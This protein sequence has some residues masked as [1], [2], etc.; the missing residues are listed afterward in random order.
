MKRESFSDKIKSKW[1]G[2]KPGWRSC[3]MIGI[4]A[5]ILYLSITY[6]PYAAKLL[7]ALL[8]ASAPILIGC[9]IAYPLNI[10]MS[11]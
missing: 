7:I 3:A 8:V 11:F 10:L 2:V 1:Q 9:V 5:F 4:S 6:W